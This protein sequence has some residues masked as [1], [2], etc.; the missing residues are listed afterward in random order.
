MLF[1]ACPLFFRFHPCS[2]FLLSFCSPSFS[3]RFFPCCSLLV[4]P[5]FISPCLSFLLQSSL[6][7]SSLSSPFFFDGLFSPFFLS[8][9]L[10]SCVHFGPFF[11]F[12]LLLYL[13]FLL[14]FTFLSVDLFFFRSSSLFLPSKQ[15]TL[16]KTASACCIG[17]GIFPPSNLRRLFFAC[18]PRHSS[19]LAVSSRFWLNTIG[20][21]K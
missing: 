4:L 7:S 14:S 2:P 20:R 5:V 19:S 12:F 11:F 21:R 15:G 3:H 18:S 6:I 1:S 10:F 8:F 16:E 17:T 9:F 13:F